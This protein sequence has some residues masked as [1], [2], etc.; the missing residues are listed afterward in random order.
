[1]SETNFDGI[2]R[3]PHP[4]IK[5][6]LDH[7]K[8]SLATFGVYYDKISGDYYLPVDN[9]WD[10]RNEKSLRLWLMAEKGLSKRNLHH[11]GELSDVD[12]T[13][14]AI[15]KANA[16]DYV[17]KLAGYQPGPIQQNGSKILI[18]KG[19]KIIEPKDG[20]CDVIDELLYVQFGELQLLYLNLWEKVAYESLTSGLFRPGQALVIAGPRDCG[21]TVLQHRILTPLLGG[22]VAKPYLYFSG[23]T[24]FNSELFEA[25]HLVI[26]DDQASTDLQAR[27]SFGNHLKQI[28]ANISQCCHPKG[29]PALTLFPGWRISTT[30]NDEPENLMILP[31]MDESLKDKLMILKGHKK[32]G[33]N[34]MPMPTGTPEERKKFEDRLDEELPA[35]IAKVKRLE[36]PPDLQS[37]RYGVKTYLNPEIV[38]QLEDRNPEFRLLEY[39]DTYNMYGDQNPWVGTATEFERDLGDAMS[40]SSTGRTALS[41]LLYH[42]DICGRY[43]SRLAEKLPSRVKKGAAKGRSRYHIWQPEEFREEKS[44]VRRVR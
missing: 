25:E 34:P 27:R 32:D 33:P 29:R 13:L 31:P 10:R 17:G 8:G 36:I 43:L 39:A 26:E 20:N 9:T 3:G 18:T 2:A 4:A 23:Q 44:K 42:H 37:G 38:Q 15:Q 14:L 16:I 41:K 19:P 28:A 21:K 40:A 1:M 11:N 22:R 7:V 24:P 12:L 5:T 30:C 35:H 6:A